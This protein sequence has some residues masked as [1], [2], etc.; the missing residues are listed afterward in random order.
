MGATSH[1]DA[2]DDRLQTGR[3]GSVRTD[4]ALPVCAEP[5]ITAPEPLLCGALAELLVVAGALVEAGA[6]E[7]GPL[8]EVDVDGDCVGVG[9]IVGVGLLGEVDGAVGD[10]LGLVGDVDGFG[11]DDVDGGFVGELDELPP[12]P[13]VPLGLSDG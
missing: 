11:V 1:D 13:F 12:D 10:V 9:V 4:P 5:Q 6:L 2:A 3:A 7:A 8:A